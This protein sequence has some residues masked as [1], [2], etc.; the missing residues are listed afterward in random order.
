VVGHRRE[1]FVDRCRKSLLD[2][3]VHHGAAHDHNDPERVKHRGGM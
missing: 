3:D 1:D 2:V